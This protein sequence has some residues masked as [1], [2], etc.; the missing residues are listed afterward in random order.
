VFEEGLFIPSIKCFD[1]GV[2][3]ETFFDF[4]RAGSRLPVELEGNVYSLCAGNDAGAKRLVQ[5]MDAFAMDSLDALAD[6]ILD[7]SSRA[8]I[9]EIA[10]LPSASSTGD[11]HA[12]QHC[13]ARRC[14]RT[15]R[16][17]L[18]LIMSPHLLSLIGVT[19][20]SSV[21]P[22]PNNVVIASI[23]AQRGVLAALPYMLGVMVGVSV[24][25][26][27]AGVGLSGL[28]TQVPRVASVLRWVAFGWIAVMAWQIATAP[29]PGEA[30]AGQ[31]PGFIAAVLFQWV[32]PTAWL[33]TVSVISAWIVPQRPLLPQIALFAAVFV[34]A[35]LPCTVLWALLGSGAARLL[36]SSARLRVFNVT[37]A[38][39]LI[40]SML[41]VVLGETG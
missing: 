23:G 26:M 16:H 1:Q 33:L 19:F 32:N 5:M 3:N 6:F 9:A 34:L 30:R 20:A 21:A 14:E 28:V 25:F 38:I 40:V 7:H 41:P 35:V 15:N 17:G 27:L 12:Q 8:T 31:S 11:N 22:G 39:L 18:L 2:A 13:R 29:L 4:I 24:V 36:H 10:K 37:M